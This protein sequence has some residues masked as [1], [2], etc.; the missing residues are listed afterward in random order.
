MTFTSA[1]SKA[2]KRHCVH[3]EPNHLT[4]RIQI[5]WHKMLALSGGLHD[6]GDSPFSLEVCL[7]TGCLSFSANLMLYSIWFWWMLETSAPCWVFPWFARVIFL[8][9]SLETIIQ[10]KGRL[11]SSLFENASLACSPFSFGRA[12]LPCGLLG[13]SEKQFYNTACD[14]RPPVF[15]TWLFHIFRTLISAK[16]LHF[17][18]PQ[19]LF[20]SSGPKGFTHRA[21]SG[22][23]PWYSQRLMVMPAKQTG[24]SQ[25]WFLTIKPRLIIQ[26]QLCLQY[27]ECYE[28]KEAS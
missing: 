18:L 27:S 8:L 4:R 9:L 6:T 12:V 7:P 26:E 19:Y 22:P 16:L 11:L 10:F 5:P 3:K 17:S 28:Y 13:F 23:R 20:L 1:D 24:N 2:G 25:K 14:V 21:S 15:R